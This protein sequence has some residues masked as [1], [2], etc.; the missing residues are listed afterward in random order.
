MWVHVW[1]LKGGPKVKLGFSWIA[2]IP[3]NSTAEGDCVHQKLIP[4]GWARAHPCAC[5]HTDTQREGGQADRQND[6]ET[7]R[8][9]VLH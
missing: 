7:K 1:D 9:A 8:E 2:E 4:Q 3:S 6:T 5:A